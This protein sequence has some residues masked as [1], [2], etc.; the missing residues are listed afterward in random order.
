MNVPEHEIRTWETEQRICDL[1][2]KFLRELVKNRIT[3]GETLQILDKAKKTVKNSVKSA[4]W[5]AILTCETALNEAHVFNREQ[6]EAEV[7][8]RKAHDSENAS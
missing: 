1:A 8:R 4:K 7:N 3:V 5:D 6:V 2:D